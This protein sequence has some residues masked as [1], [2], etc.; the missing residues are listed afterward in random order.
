MNFAL[1]GASWRLK[2]CRQFVFTRLKQKKP[3]TKKRSQICFGT[4][5]FYSYFFYSLQKRQLIQ[6]GWH[7]S[8]LF[9]FAQSPKPARCE[10]V[11]A[12]PDK[13]NGQLHSH[14]EANSGSDPRSNLSSSF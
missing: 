5:F 7:S 6:T 9:V 8:E 12:E 4:A 11:I 13:L 3:K 2:V 10:T 14:K 1:N